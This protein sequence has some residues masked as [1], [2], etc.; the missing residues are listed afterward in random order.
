MQP[1]GPVAVAGFTASEHAVTIYTVDGHPI[2]LDATSYRTK[3]VLDDIIDKMAAMRASNSAGAPVVEIDI[4]AFSISKKI[5]DNSG[6]AVRVLLNEKNQPAVIQ[7]GS[8]QIADGVEKLGRH[9]ELAAQNTHSALALENFI[10]RFSRVQTSRKHTADELLDFVKRNDLPIAQDGRIIA[11]K[12]LRTDAKVPHDFGAGYWFDKHSGRVPQRP[13]SLVMMPANAVDESRRHQ[14][15]TGFHVCSVEYW[16]GFWNSGDPITITLVDPADIIAV[17]RNESTKM[18]ACAYFVAAAVDREHVAMI[19]ASKGHSDIKAVQELVAQVAAG[20]HE[21]VLETV[22]QDADGSVTIT[23]SSD[24]KPRT[25]RRRIKR[26]KR[27]DGAPKSAPAVIDAGALREKLSDALEGKQ[28][29]RTEKVELAKQLIESRGLSIRSVATQLS[30]SGSWLKKS[31]DAEGW[32]PRA[33]PVDAH[34]QSTTTAKLGIALK[35][36]AEGKSLREASRVSGVAR[37]TLQDQVRRSKAAPPTPTG[38]IAPAADQ[39]SRD[40]RVEAAIRL[41]KDEGW[42]VKRAAKA[43]GLSDSRLGKT[44]KSRT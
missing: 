6:G 35:M 32:K 9:I 40:A 12:I 38:P 16:Q 43:H 4:N 15:S 33:V 37:S 3:E 28:R 26:S 42:S 44:L 8:I 36:L 10:K 20:H 22:F 19:Y 34:M 27:G 13:G 29:P 5:E 41:V 39:T 31:L 17:P 25:H 2:T 30:M 24:A 7:V 1:N 21:P 23:P 14:C 18:R 11:F